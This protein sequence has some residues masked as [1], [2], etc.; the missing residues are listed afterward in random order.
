M[1]TFWE[2]LKAGYA[3]FSQSGSVAL[4]PDGRSSDE[5]LPGMM[6]SFNSMFGSVSPVVSF[7][8]LA[9]LKNLWLYN[10]DFSQYVANIVNLGNPGH[11][12]T[13]EAANDAR[14]EAA[15]NRINESASRIYPNACGVDG[16]LNAYITSVAWSGAVS[17]EDVVNLASRRVEKV[18]LVPVEQIRFKYNKEIDSYEAYQRSNNLLRKPA[19]LGMIKLNAETYKYFALST[20]ENS[21]YAKPPATAAVEA[22]L[23]G[24]VPIMENLRFM[25]QKLGLLGFID[26]AV[27]GPNKKFGREVDEEHS[28]RVSDYIA[29]VAKALEGSLS[30]GL[31]VHPKDHAIKHEPV[32]TGAAGV[33]E[34]NTVSEQQ[35][36]S[37]MG[38]QPGFHG[39]TDSTTETF[40]DVVYYLLTAQTSNMQ[41]PAKR[42]QEATYRLDLRLGGIDV[43]SVS[44]SFNKAHS[45]NA[46]AEAET[47]EIT[48]R[49]AI[50]KVEK[51]IIAPDQAAQELGYDSWF[52]V[53]L[54]AGEPATSAKL[55]AR[56]FGA[57]DTNQTATKVLRMSFDKK[58]QRYIHQP[59]VVQLW[60]GD[61]EQPGRIDT[62]VVVPFLKKKALK[63]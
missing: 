3:A 43:D 1:M 7:E 17:S 46:K 55:Q 49:T 10:P 13:I 63:A 4:P 35:V 25:A 18:V 57:H 31:L 26:Y 45:R 44:L 48:L 54:I 24:Q 38:A 39:R 21:P 50:S 30:K 9:T 20:V 6:S 11:Q 62:D 5:T 27:T 53:E 47:D 58:L 33:A 16:L 61:D 29:N 41:R 52:D 22:I 40:A 51:G 2:K 8:M 28:K 36:F 42:R 37:G 15:L 19:D 56:A 23:Q 32:T 14:A 34:V 60:S 12:I 59:D